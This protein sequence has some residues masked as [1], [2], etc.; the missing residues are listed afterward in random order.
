MTIR[1]WISREEF[2]E[3]NFNFCVIEYIREQLDPK[4]KINGVI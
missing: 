1:K 2:I 4:H 3:R